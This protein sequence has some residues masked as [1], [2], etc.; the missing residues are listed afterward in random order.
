MDGY[1]T[2]FFTGKSGRTKDLRDEINE[3][4]KEKGKAISEVYTSIALGDGGLVIACVT[5]KETPQ[6]Y[7]P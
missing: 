3:W 1:A 6:G 5:Y 2:E 7:Q 4:M